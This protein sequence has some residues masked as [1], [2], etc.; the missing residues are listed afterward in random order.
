MVCELWRLRTSFSD[1][2][3][4]SWAIWGF[5]H[6]SYH[7]GLHLMG[8][9]KHQAA[10]LGHCREQQPVLPGK[11]GHVPQAACPGWA[12]GTVTVAVVN[13][14]G[15]KLLQGTV[16]GTGPVVTAASGVTSFAQVLIRCCTRAC[17]YPSGQAAALFA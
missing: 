4:S 6:D 15:R 8:A 2:G 11:G 7:G 16:I 5:T 13:G 1:Q 3:S 10:F 17:S 14:P 9:V 12:G